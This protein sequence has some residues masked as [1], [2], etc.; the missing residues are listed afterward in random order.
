MFNDGR[1]Q[2]SREKLLRYLALPFALGLVAAEEVKGLRP[3]LKADMDDRIVLEKRA[4]EG[5]WF[6][7]MGWYAR[8][9]QRDAARESG[10]KPT[11]VLC[12][13]F[14]GSG[15]QMESLAGQLK[16]KG[17]DCLAPDLLGFG[18]SHKP[19]LLY[20]QYLWEVR[21]CEERSDRA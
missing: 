8:Y 5:G 11:V 14:G 12:H 20:T 19:R 2:E 3:E 6:L 18:R 4:R 21:E 16:E 7:W 1:V 15:S 17:Y 13:G 9:V 10:Q